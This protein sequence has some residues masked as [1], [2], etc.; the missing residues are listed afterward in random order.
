[1]PLSRIVFNTVGRI[2]KASRGSEDPRVIESDV[3]RLIRGII[4]A[5]APGAAGSS[6]AVDSVVKSCR[7]R[8]E[9]GLGKYPITTCFR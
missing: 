9:G 6:V 1:M 5:P 4:Q 3:R 2:D 8:R 7:S